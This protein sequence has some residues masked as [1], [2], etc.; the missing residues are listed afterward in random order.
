MSERRRWLERGKS[1][2]ILLLSLSALWLLS[3]TPLIRDSGI[4]DLFR[5][6]SGG[7]EGA[8]SVTL[9]AAARPSR[10]AVHNG[11]E[12]YG[13]QYDQG[14]ADELFARLGP[15]LG[16]ALTSS[17]APSPI[18]ERRWQ[19]Y[20]QG[21]SIYFDF[22]GEI[23]LSALGGWLSQEG[24]CSLTASAR[25]VLLAGDGTDG[26]LL[27]YQDADSGRFYACGTGLTESLHLG[28]AVEG[29]AGNGALFAFESEVWSPLLQPYT[30]ITEDSGRRVYAASTPLSP[31]GDLSALLETLDYS[32][33]NHTPVSGGELYLDGSDRLRVL[34]GGQVVYNAAQGGKYPVATA[35]SEMTVAEAIEAA[36]EIAENTIGTQCGAAELYLISAAAAED[37]YRI[38]FGYRLDGSTVWL[39]D[40]GW[41]AEFLIRNGYV[42]DFTLCYRCYVDGGEEALLLPMDRAAAMLPDLTGERCELILQYRDRGESAVLPV[43]VAG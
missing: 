13:V 33:Y 38:R 7:T 20:L 41:A 5:P 6:N 9:T 37:G 36:R 15:L 28:P 23:P 39:Y 29:V 40:E 31:S 12:R 1:L 32:G 18:P 17:A 16:E 35:G 24:Q 25:R 21:K 4:P 30:L 10:V 42:T 19:R 26:V 2:L 43:W 22:T 8:A 11:G 3:M 27:C 14:A 34:T